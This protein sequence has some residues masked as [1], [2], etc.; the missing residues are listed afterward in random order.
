[1]KILYSAFDP[2]PWPKGSGTRIEATVRALAAAGA[3]V[4]LHTPEPSRALE[5]FARRLEVENVHHQPVPIDDEHFLDRVLA[6]RASVEELLR[7][8]SFDAAIFRSPW[9][10]LPIVKAVPRSVYEVHGF[11]SVELSSHY[12]AIANAPRLLDRL[13]AEE[14]FCLGQSRLFLT[15]SGTSRHFLMRRG[16]SP[17]DIRIIPNSVELAE[18]EER[19][20]TATT[21]PPYRIGYMGTL[22]P[23]QGIGLLLEAFAMLRREHDSRLVMVGTRKGRWTRPLLDMARRL[24]VRSLLEF[25]GAAPKEEV[26]RI[27]RSCD[28]LVAPLPNDPRNGLQGCCPIKI[29]EYMTLGRPIVSTKIAPVQELLDDQRTAILVSPGS[30]SSLAWGLRKVL[31]DRALAQGL[32]DN[33]AEHVRSNFPRHRFASQIS[34]VVSELGAMSDRNSS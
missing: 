6:F 10:G 9:E 29:L 7:S 21:E 24:K 19:I 1:V 25:H 23:W 13:I 22:A 16:V 32:A 27:L 15:P 2:V 28:V 20:P 17:E 5:G 12:P 11:P 14:N 8:E 30:A 18:P 33:A 31:T 3:T 34:D 26:W 4:H